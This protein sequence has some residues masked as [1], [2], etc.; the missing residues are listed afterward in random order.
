MVTRAATM[1]CQ[2]GVNI[3]G[4]LLSGWDEQYLAGGSGD[5]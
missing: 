3:V 1:W 5:I 4:E 2:N